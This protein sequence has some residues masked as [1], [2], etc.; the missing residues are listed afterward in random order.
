MMLNLV[1]CGSPQVTEEPSTED[2]V[3][4]EAVEVTPLILATTTSTLDTGLLDVLNAAFEEEFPQYQVKA[5]AVGTG[6]ALK[7]GERKEADVVL[8]HSRAAEDEFVE[9]GYGFDRRDVMYNDYVLVGPGEDPAGIKG[10]D[11]AEAFKT[12]AAQGAVF[13]SRGDD[14]GTHKKEMS[15]WSK[16]G[17][18][19][20]GQWYFISGQGMGATLQI[21][22][23]KRGYTLSDRG[24]FLASSNLGLVV[25]VEKE[26]ALLNPYGVIQ[27]T[28]AKNAEGALAYA[29]FITSPAGQAIIAEFGKDKYG[30]PLFF[31]DAE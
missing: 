28:G 16:A 31:P 21:A 10:M 26:P 1:G 9:A 19:P 20:G 8:V 11:S 12:I 22:D 13:L 24:T 23:E 4:P 17:V 15:I 25:L 5:I 2:P 27:V 6:E 7:M 18:E 14:S 30:Q 3:Q 29:G